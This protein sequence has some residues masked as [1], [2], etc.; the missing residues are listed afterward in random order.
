MT[1]LALP[2]KI[3]VPEKFLEEETRDGYIVSTTMKQVWAV[4]IDLLFQFI[5]ICDKYQLNWMASG[6]TALGAVRHEGFIP[7][8]DDIDI[9]MP[10]KDY[11]KFCIVATNELE[12]PYFFSNG[13][14][15]K[16]IYRG[17]A[18][19]RNSLTT[20]ILMDHWNKGY[21]FNQGIF[22]DVFPQ[23][24]L[25][26]DLT[27]RNGY[28]NELSIQFHKTQL[29]VDR[30]DCYKTLKGQGIIN[31]LRHLSG[32]WLSIL[33]K[34]Y[35]ISMMERLWVR[36]RNTP[37]C[38]ILGLI[39]FDNNCIYAK[40]ICYPVQMMNFEWF[41]IPVPHDAEEYLRQSFGDWKTPVMGTSIH[42]NVFFDPL[43]PYS[44]YVE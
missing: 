21:A 8:D 13:R 3:N 7:W 29:C 40:N 17:H 32:H 37:F 44:Q 26:S 5:R 6:G 30:A 14:N 1:D 24:D 4:E 20:G 9:E 27:E 39:P 25:P 12:F 10:R 16:Q 2:I 41:Q 28:L 35:Q 18:Q 43:R 36:Y 31:Y 19:L 34:P 15:E 33:T 11:E 42:G 22:I 23:D 38:S